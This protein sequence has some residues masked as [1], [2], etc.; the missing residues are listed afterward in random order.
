MQNRWLSDD[1]LIG[2]DADIADAY[3]AIGNAPH[4]AGPTIALPESRG[5]RGRIAQSVEHGPVAEFHN[6]TLEEGQ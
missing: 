2:F 3:V 6:F 5:H 4:V 1:N